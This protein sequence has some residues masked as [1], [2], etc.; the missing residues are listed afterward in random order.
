MY[1][2]F[3]SSE[4]CLH[5]CDNNVPYVNTTLLNDT[6][7]SSRPS[8]YLCT[9]G[10]LF[11]QRECTKMSVVA[12]RVSALNLR[13]RGYCTTPASSSQ[14]QTVTVRQRVSRHA[15]DAYGQLTGGNRT[16]LPFFD[17]AREEHHILLMLG[18]KTHI[19]YRYFNKQRI[20]ARFFR[21]LKCKYLYR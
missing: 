14:Q 16:Y 7:Y 6:H 8:V 12:R 21:L 2:T 4:A 17:S 10:S 13:S 9:H 18:R 11:F 3:I 20:W 1:R 15:V 19:S 5:L